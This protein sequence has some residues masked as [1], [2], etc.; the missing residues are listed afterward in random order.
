MT[1]EEIFSLWAPEES[2][3]SSWAKP[4]LFAHLRPSEELLQ[5]GF[6]LPQGQA[7]WAPPEG[8]KT[9]I[10]LDLPSDQGVWV[11]LA[12]AKRG[13][14]PVPLYNAI[15]LPAESALSEAQSQR[16][17]AAVDM[18]PI[19]AALASGAEVLA[20]TPIPSDAPPVFLLDARRG[21]DAMP[22]GHGQF[23]N[24]SVCFTTDFPSANFLLSHGISRVL[25]VQQGRREPLSDLAHIL[26]RWQEGG[27]SLE[28]M[29][30][31]SPEGRMP[32]QARRPTWYGAMFQ[33]ALCALGLRWSGGAG[34]FGG[35]M[36]DSSAG[37]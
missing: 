2:V 14:R 30:L 18:V 16:P 24:R 7:P 26:S 29:P 37:G 33:R 9:A 31:E 34:G 6:G 19:T 4:V 5:D 28:R 20:N 1:T 15:P 3:W 23:D 27:V 21:G 25:L 22:L 8:E 13:Y 11:G 17:I 35:W 12:L 36:A 32:F 10:V